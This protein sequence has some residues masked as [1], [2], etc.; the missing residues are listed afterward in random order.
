MIARRTS[1]L[2][3]TVALAAMLAG[4]MGRGGANVTGSIGPTQIRSEQDWRSELQRWQSAYDSNPRDRAAILGYGR[5]LRGVGQH[6]QA[7][8]VLQGGVVQHA[9]DLELLG[10]YGR[11]LMDAGQ[12]KQAEDV[13]SRAHLPERPDW[14][15]LSAQGAVADQLGDHARAQGYYNAALRLNPGDPSVLSNLGLSYALSKRLPEA[16]RALLQASQHPAA[17]KRVRQNLMLVYGLQGR[18]REA[19]QIAQADLPAAEAGKAIAQLR[20]M[21]AQQNS[22]EAIRRTDQTRG[23]RPAAPAA[24]RR[25]AGAD[26]SRPQG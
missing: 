17:D 25:P 13:L 20:Q 15:I 3:A 1:S 21:T 19:E 6:K 8:A 5:A 16:E 18:F 26:T 4:C 10:A 14:R 2:L 11:A 24:A 12:L 9:N 22:W 7:V 23:S